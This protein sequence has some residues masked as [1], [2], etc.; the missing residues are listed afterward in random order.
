M[1]AQSQAPGGAEPRGQGPSGAFARDA[2]TVVLLRES[3]GGGP[4]ELLLLQRHARAGFAPTAWVFPGGTVDQADMRLEPACWDGLDPAAVAPLVGRAPGLTLGLFVAAVRE[5]FEEA[6]VLLARRADGRPVDHAEVMAMRQAL[7]A[8]PE[9]GAKDEDVTAA[10]NAWVAGAGLVLD[11]GALTPLSRWITPAQEPRRYDTIFFLARAPEEQTAA[12]D[13]VETTES[14]WLTAADALSAHTAGD[15]RLVFPTIRTLEEL[16]GFAD[17]PTLLAA[18][19]ARG[20]LRPLQPHLIV[21]ENGKVTG[22]LHP[23][24]PDYPWPLYPGQ[25]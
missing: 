22:I 15:L 14:R 8:P 24:D 20:R 23:D 6:G 16:A 13:R 19:A 21:D 7:A 12:H 5:T 2:A 3:P 11:L 1:G 25:R 17:T 9:R 4:P 18:A 10:F